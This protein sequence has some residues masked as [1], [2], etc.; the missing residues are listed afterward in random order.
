VR[1]V[2]PDSPRSRRLVSG[3]VGALP[4]GAS[5]IATVVSPN[6]RRHQGR[7]RG[8]SPRPVRGATRCFLR[9][10]HR[11]PVRQQYAS[12]SND[13]PDSVLRR[14]AHGPGADGGRESV[15]GR[16]SAGPL[17]HDADGYGAHGQAATL[18]RGTRFPPHPWFKR[19]SEAL[20][21]LGYAYTR[22][23]AH[24]DVSPR[25][26]VSMGAAPARTSFAR[27]LDADVRW[28]LSCCRCARGHGYFPRRRGEEARVPVRVS[29]ASRARIG[30]SADG[31]GLRD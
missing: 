30:V 9:R 8:R 2:L 7:P 19:W 24:L 4:R 16:V 6:G 27:M 5:R 14:R 23:A 11:T 26:T 28:L 22:N 29:A 18:L 20:A 3:G 12:G 13:T 21:P 1:H 15:S 10:T 31:G 17:A 25:P